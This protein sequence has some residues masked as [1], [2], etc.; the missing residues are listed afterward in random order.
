M[1]VG[2]PSAYSMFYYSLTEPE[3]GARPVPIFLAQ[4][5]N[6]RQA[7]ALARASSTLLFH[8]SGLLDLWAAERLESI[9]FIDSF[10]NISDGW[11]IGFQMSGLPQF[12]PALPVIDH[13]YLNQ[14]VGNLVYSRFAVVS[15]ARGK[16][17]VLPFRTRQSGNYEVLVR[18]L[19][20][21]G[22]G[23][24]EVS[25]DGVSQ[26]AY[27]LNKRSGFWWTSLGRFDFGRGKHELNLKTL[28][29]KLVVIDG[30]IVE[31][32]ATLHT[33]V[34]EARTRFA[35]LK[36]AYLTTAD[37]FHPMS[38]E[39][40]V[41]W[42]DVRRPGS[43]R[44]AIEAAHPMSVLVNGEP[45]DDSKTMALEAGL[46]EVTVLGSPEGF[47]SLLIEAVSEET[48]QQWMNAFS[49]TRISA[50]EYRYKGDAARPCLIVQPETHFEGWQAQA[51][52]ELVQP[53]SAHLFLNAYAVVER[54]EIEGRIFYR[55]R[56]F[57]ALAL[58]SITVLVGMLALA[59]FF[60]IRRKPSLH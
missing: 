20:T 50:D 41:S 45:F 32:P 43:Y 5:A 58:L 26:G 30:V 31:S 38:P 3:G 57:T 14:L 24:V 1:T 33:G 16:T 56:L 40:R 51:N 18:A 19:H 13:G 39:K 4:Q 55:N 37:R 35:W 17:L 12:N 34:E 25:L 36:D 15:R 28:E 27:K 21:A 53:L 54:G 7:Q 48:D 10:E 47:D 11:D 60:L 22:A 42:V 44:Y 46:H 6:A 59:V 29:D 23:S 52:G 8:N 49:Y 9:N 2:G